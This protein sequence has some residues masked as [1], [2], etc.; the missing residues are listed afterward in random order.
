MQKQLIKT[1][2]GLTTSQTGILGQVRYFT[3]KITGI[4]N[5]SKDKTKDKEYINADLFAQ[6]TYMAAISSSGLDRALIFNA[7]AKL[8]Y[9]SSTYFKDITSMVHK[10]SYDYPEACRIVGEKTME[11]DPRAI[12]LRFAGTLASGESEQIFLSREAEVQGE[13][14]G[15]AYERDLQALKSWTDAYVALLLSASLIIIVAVISMMIYPVENSFLFILSGMT[16]MVTVAGAWILHRAAP[17]EI[18]THCLQETSK[19]QS[20]AQYLF[21]IM[22]PAGV[23]ISSIMAFL[24]VDIGVILLVA[25]VFV[26]PTGMVIILDDRKIDKHDHDIAGVIRSLG[27]AA[28]A[29]ASTVNHA[30]NR[31]DLRSTNSLQNSMKTLKTR[32]LTGISSNLCW[33]KFVS[34][35]GSEM[36]HRSLQIFRDSVDLGADPQ[37]AGEQASFYAMKINLLRAKRNLISS[38]FT[39]LTMVMHLVVCALMLF[40]SGVLGIFANTLGNMEE[41]TS[42]ERSSSLPTFG[43]FGDSAQLA[44]FDNLVIMVIIIFTVANAFAIRAVAG[45]HQ[46]KFLFYLGIMLAMSGLCFIMT[47]TFLQMVLGGLAPMS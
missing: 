28:K 33:E 18:K 25:A 14:Y 26:L 15:N 36:V 17:K 7:A 22:I 35:T 38:G 5:S 1:E 2:Q 37:F 16:I 34:E 44:L 30:V 29:I 20:L 32:L 43:F 3:E 21:K 31:I 27:G 45:G 10:L 12:L 13:S 42:I 4:I 46:Y 24:N 11:A 47:P 8:P 23:V 40:I 6:M 39:W 19:G 9:S 41:T